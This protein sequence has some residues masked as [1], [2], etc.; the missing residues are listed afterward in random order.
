MR[1]R[2]SGQLANYKPRRKDEVIVCSDPEG[3]FRDIEATIDYWFWFRQRLLKYGESVQIISPQKLADEIKK[4]YQKIWE[5]LS[6]VESS[7]NQS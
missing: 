2:T 7:R 4:E 3:K 5:K 1:Y 6:A